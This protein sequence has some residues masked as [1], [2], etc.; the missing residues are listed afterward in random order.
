MGAK[1]HGARLVASMKTYGIFRIV[2]FNVS[3]F[4]RFTGIEAMHPD[5]AV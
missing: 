2:T 5:K 4:T 1:V 3:D